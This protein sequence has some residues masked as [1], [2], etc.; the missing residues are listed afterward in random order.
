MADESWLRRIGFAL[1]KRRVVP[2][3]PPGRVAHASAGEPAGVVPRSPPDHAAAWS[4]FISYT[5]A[6]GETSARTITIRRIYSEFD[7][8]TTIM[9]YCH[10]REDIRS[11]S[12]ANISE[13][14][15]VDTGEVLDP[16]E[17][18]LALHRCGA[19]KIEDRVLTRLMRLM[20]FMARCDGNFHALER[21]TLDDVLGRYFRFFGGD[22]AAYACAIAE[23]PRLAP[24]SAE[25][26]KDL[27]WLTRAPRRAQLARFTLDCTA[28][29]IAADGRQT[30]EEIA[31]GLEVSDALKRM[32]GRA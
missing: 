2:P 3:D 12:I 29:M 26:M 20:T 31:W 11:F 23:A 25:F 19:L 17:N 5:D 7:Q 30:E 6:K 32:A 10:L 9:A 4:A 28:E 24:T 1:G 15:C 8:P 18:C 16:L 21:E 22:D 13:M 27:R 14:V